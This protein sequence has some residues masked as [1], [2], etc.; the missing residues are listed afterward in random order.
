MSIATDLQVPEQVEVVDGVYRGKWGYYPCD[1]ATFI[2]IK[3]L[4][5]Y[6]LHDLRSTRQRDRWMAKLP[7]NRKGQCR[8]C[9]GI[10]GDFYGRI[11][12]EYR[13]A[14]H[15]ALTESSV[16]KLDLPRGWRSKLG[17]LRGIHGMLK[18]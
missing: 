6:A 13:N 9:A 17:M 1:K 15:P 5:R 7:H 2:H 3:E 4:H 12:E 14:R 16:K 11:L 8:E 10:S 18:R